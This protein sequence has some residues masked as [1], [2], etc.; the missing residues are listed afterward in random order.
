MSIRQILTQLQADIN[1]FGEIRPLQLLLLLDAMIDM[2]QRLT[3]L[4]PGKTVRTRS[5]SCLL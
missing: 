3:Q 1:R 4:E 5:H 2:D